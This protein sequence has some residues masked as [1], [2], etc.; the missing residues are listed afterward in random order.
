MKSRV[1]IFRKTGATTQDETSG[2]EVDEWAAL[3]MDVPFRSSP[4]GTRTVEVGGVIYEDAT[5]VGHLPADFT[6]LED[7]DHLLVTAG[8]WVGDV[9]RVVA[10]VRHDQQTARRVPIVE[11]QRPEGW[12]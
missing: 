3:A 2:R 10:A 12:T 11:A 8:E 6:D 7:G 1:T 5:G 9:F 4:Q